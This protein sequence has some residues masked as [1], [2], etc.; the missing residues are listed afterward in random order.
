MTARAPSRS[1]LRAAIL[2]IAALGA[3]PV[4]HAVADGPASPAP[5][6][7][8]APPPAAASSQTLDALT[9][10]ERE[11]V[12]RKVPDWDRLD[13]A[14]QGRI[15]SVVTRVRTLP[16]EQR[17]LF[18]A[19]MRRLQRAGPMAVETF[20]KNLPAFAGAS[21]ERR[22][23]V[24]RVHVV[25]RAVA[26]SYAASWPVE[27]RDA[28]LGTGTGALSPQERMQ[29][30]VCV[31]GAWR[32]RAIE[33][34]V[35]A[36]LLDVEPVEGTPPARATEFVT[37]RDQVRLGGGVASTEG[38]RRRYAVRVFDDQ[39][40]RVKSALGKRS[41]PQ[42]GAGGDVVDA[43]LAKLGDRLRA[44]FPAASES[45]GAELLAA[46]TKGRD[47]L[48]AFCEKNAPERPPMRQRKMWELLLLLEEKRAEVGGE[49]LARMDDLGA[50]ILTS[51]RV[52]DDRARA[53]RAATFPFARA[54]L[55]R[56]LFDDF[57]PQAPRAPQSP[58]APPA[59]DA[60]DK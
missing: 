37:L 13:A 33:A 21:P 4:G 26:A 6:P 43:H 46:V 23:E 59:G 1:L 38:L 17:E 18:L 30:A 53:L 32:R 3:F 57:G 29:L 47:G 35:Q 50:A 14:T 15:V 8:P 16:P 24:A 5:A 49:V 19:R 39:V 20:A 25:A 7:A 41:M 31:G 11:L 45:V 34:L 27:V 52:P 55:L 12:R 28:L 2:A 22:E 10:E 44:A 56:K 58:P 60:R 9:S 36:P 40:L 48:A 51:L 42:S 54:R